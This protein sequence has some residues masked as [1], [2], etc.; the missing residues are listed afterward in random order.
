MGISIPILPQTRRNKPYL[1][2][3]LLAY[4]T[5]FLLVACVSSGL[6]AI[7]LLIGVQFDAKNLL[8][9]DWKGTAVLYGALGGVVLSPLAF[10]ASLLYHHLSPKY[11]NPTSD[12]LA[13]YHSQMIFSLRYWV[14]ILIAAC[15][16]PGVG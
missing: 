1:C 11:P 12:E 16:A 8:N 15:I 10:L 2:L 5:N 4:L 9:L 6:G 13:D 7:F 14:W 3:T